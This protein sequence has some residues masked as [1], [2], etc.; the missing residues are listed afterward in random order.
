MTE[1]STRRPV[2]QPKADSALSGAPDF[3][4]GEDFRLKHSIG[5]PLRIYMDL[6]ADVEMAKDD[7]T[8]EQLGA[9]AWH[10]FHFGRHGSRSLANCARGYGNHVPH[11]QPPGCLWSGAPETLR[12]GRPRDAPPVAQRAAAAKFHAPRR[13]S[14]TGSSGD[15]RRR[16][17][18]R[19][20]RW[21][22]RCSPMPRRP[23]RNSSP[24]AVASIVRSL[25][26]WP[27]SSRFSSRVP[28]CTGHLCPSADYDAWILRM[29]TIWPR[30]STAMQTPTCAD[31]GNDRLPTG[32]LSEHGAVSIATPPWIPHYRLM[33]VLRAF[34]SFH[35]DASQ[36]SRPTVHRA[37]DRGRLPGVCSRYGW[38][39]GIDF[40]EDW[41]GL[42]PARATN[43]R[44]WVDT[45]SVHVNRS[46]PS[47]GYDGHCP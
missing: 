26:A 40:S 2:S 27:R 29:P 19:S 24:S 14:S 39:R 16:S 25:L 15:S 32:A 11:A 18:R 22:T 28:A 46:S 10:L 41:P 31:P 44:V 6:F 33:H 21:S 23:E 7:L 35:S 5:C 13:A 8:S 12:Q 43:A 3:H 36:G 9:A 34:T 47:R 45:Q 30:S 20:R 42:D 38:A 1:N 37:A 4:R 17:S